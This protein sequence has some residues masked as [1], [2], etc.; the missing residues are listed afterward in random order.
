M[1]CPVHTSTAGYPYLQHSAWTRLRDWVPYTLGEGPR[2]LAG[3]QFVVDQAREAGAGPDALEN[4][5]AAQRV[6]RQVVMTAAI[7]APPELWLLRHVLAALDRVGV[8]DRLLAG[9]VL[10]PTDCPPLL[11]EDLDGDCEVDFEDLLLML[12]N[13][14]P[15]R[16]CGRP[17]STSAS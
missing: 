14:G 2:V 6:V 5:A 10:H 3:A 8:S 13:W 11:A 7:T 15:C 16:P 1:T 4:L 9:E 17:C 12:A